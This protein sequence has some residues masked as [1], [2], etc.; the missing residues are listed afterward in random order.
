MHLVSERAE[1]E[2]EEEDARFAELVAFENGDASGR[3]ADAADSAGACT[4]IQSGPHGSGPPSGAAGL[5]DVLASFAG[6]GSHGG[7][8]D[9]GDASA[10]MRGS[11]GEPGHHRRD[12]SYESALGEFRAPG[13]LLLARRASRVR[14][15]RRTRTAAARARAPR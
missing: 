5:A 15:A 1:A 7:S 8:R 6:G 3:V 4:G 13:P 14:R 12:T 11:R 2:E 10:H 9:G